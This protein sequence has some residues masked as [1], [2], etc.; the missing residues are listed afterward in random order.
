M[1]RSWRSGVKLIPH[2]A[3]TPDKIALVHSDFS[4][5]EDCRSETS[6]VSLLLH[7][8]DSGEEYEMR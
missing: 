1:E 8:S 3:D 4:W 2:G 5:E 7:Q 6:S